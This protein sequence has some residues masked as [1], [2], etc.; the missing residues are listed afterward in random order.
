[1]QS[2]RLGWGKPAFELVTLAQE[3][4]PGP[5]ISLSDSPPN[6]LT[7]RVGVWVQ[8][9]GKGASCRRWEIKVGPEG[10][11]RSERRVQGGTGQV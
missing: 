6:S 7:M 1:M 9:M 10:W 4:P 8:L 2:T 5:G 11:V 3:A